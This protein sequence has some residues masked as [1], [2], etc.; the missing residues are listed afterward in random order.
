MQSQSQLLIVLAVFT[1]ADTIVSLKC[2]LTS[3]GLP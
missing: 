1:S 2:Q 3:Q